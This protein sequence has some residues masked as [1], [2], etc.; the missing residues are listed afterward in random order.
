MAFKCIS[1]LVPWSKTPLPYLRRIERSWGSF[2]YKTSLHYLPLLYSF[3]AFEHLLVYPVYR[4]KPG[5]CS[6]LGYVGRH[7]HLNFQLTGFVQPSKI[8]QK[9]KNF[10]L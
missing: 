10:R 5:F 9:I 8:K 2:K 1:G 7:Y 6:I 4:S 3:Q